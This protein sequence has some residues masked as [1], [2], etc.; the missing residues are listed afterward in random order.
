MIKR[1]RHKFAR[2]DPDFAALHNYPG[3]GYR[4][5]RDG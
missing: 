5:L 3:F 1:I 2:L 4:W